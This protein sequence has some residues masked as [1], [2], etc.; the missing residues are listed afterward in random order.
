MPIGTFT[1][2]IADQSKISISAPPSTGPSP[3]PKPAIVAQIPI[4]QGRRSGSKASTRIDSESG[5]S[6]AAPMPCSARNAISM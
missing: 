3:K 1:Q 4:A 2:K 6:S 5:A